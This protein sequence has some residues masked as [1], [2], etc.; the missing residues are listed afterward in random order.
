MIETPGYGSAID[1]KNTGPLEFPIK[2]S[3]QPFL[4]KYVQERF[5]LIQG[6]NSLYT[7]PLSD[8]TTSVL[9]C[10]ETDGVSTDGG[11]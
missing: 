6:E 11:L 7:V 8:V 5:K 10:L 9:I 3:I 1:V 2:A 4:L